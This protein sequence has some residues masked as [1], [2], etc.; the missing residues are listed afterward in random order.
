MGEIHRGAKAGRDLRMSTLDDPEFLGIACEV[1][2]RFKAHEQYKGE[3][4][5][6]K[7]LARR[8]PGFSPE[9][10]RSLFDLLCKVY[11]RARDLATE[12]C[13]RPNAKPGK[14]ADPSDIDFEACLRELDEIEPGVAAPAKSALM[15]WAIFWYYLK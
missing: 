4:G 13:Y 15:N 9:Q 5:A 6:V 1:V 14:H 10:Y 3:N 7:A 11:D 8:A 12:Y 2:V